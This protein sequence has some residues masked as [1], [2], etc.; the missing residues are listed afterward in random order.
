MESPQTEP[1]DPWA[2]IEAQRRLVKAST[3]IVS[4]DFCG[5][6]DNAR[7]LERQRVQAELA[8]KDAVIAELRAIIAE[9][10]KC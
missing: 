6:V 2:H 5:D 8:G 4:F 3:G 9:R 7:A 10:A 1:I